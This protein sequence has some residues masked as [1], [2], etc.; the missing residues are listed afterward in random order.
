MLGIWFNHED[1]RLRS[2]KHKDFSVLKM[3]GVT[4]AYILVKGMED[5]IRITEDLFLHTKFLFR[6]M[7]KLGIRTHGVFICSHDEYYCKKYPDRA[8]SS[9]F[10]D[11]ST[12]RISHVDPYY[13]EYLEDSV[14][15]ANDIFDMDGIQL[16]FLRYGIV[17]NGWSKLEEQIYEEHGLNVQTFK[18]ELLEHYDSNKAGYNLLSI[19]SRYYQ[20]DEQLISFVNG[21]RSVIKG[22]VRSLSEA[23]REKLP[24]K[25]LSIAMMPEG[26]LPDQKGFALFH[27]GQD[28]NDF[29]SF[30]DRLFPMAYAGAYGKKSDWVGSV[31]KSASL[32]LKGAVM[33]L[34]CTEPR[35]AMDIQGDLNEVTK[36]KNDGFC[37]FRYGRMIFALEEDN[38]TLLFNTYPGTVMSLLL[39]KSDEQEEKNFEIE[40]GSWLRINGH[41]DIIRAFGSFR[42]DS[43]S[44]YEGEL[45]VVKE[46]SKY[47]K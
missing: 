43:Q 14:F 47:N 11:K 34:E 6:E 7:K 46:P 8:D 19:V 20:N 18:R 33:G 30:A 12:R 37:L 10:G 32:S 26:L 24:E 4:D 25:E 42:T 31:A 35:T 17:A 1:Y 27:Y 13:L 44:V 39:V 45:C 5:D 23:I 9:L 2:K 21:R 29:A 28:Y 36:Y 22:F 16:D 41:F 15:T 40:E 38:D 3:A